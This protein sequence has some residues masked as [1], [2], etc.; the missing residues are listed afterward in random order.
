[1]MFREYCEPCSRFRRVRL[2]LV[3]PE[4]EELRT[5][6]ELL[7]NAP[8]LR[9]E[10]AARQERSNGLRGKLAGERYQLRLSYC[11]ACRDGILAIEHLVGA[12]DQKKGAVIESQPADAQ[13]VAA[14]LA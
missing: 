4:Q 2:L 6:L 11:P 5:V 1:M 7:G 8:R 10:L 14:L 3:A 12:A 13:A 9:Q